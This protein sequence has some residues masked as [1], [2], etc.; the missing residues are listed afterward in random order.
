[1]GE[2][3]RE[4][5]EERSRSLAGEQAQNSGQK[6]RNRTMAISRELKEQKRNERPLA[7]RRATPEEIARLV[8]DTPP[9]DFDAWMAE[10]RPGDWTPEDEAE[11]QDWLAEREA[12]RQHSSQRLEE[13]LAGLGE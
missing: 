2:F 12:M 1:M 8:A 10:A 5:E 6:G 4:R 7:Y 9:F 11:V 3:L 13:K